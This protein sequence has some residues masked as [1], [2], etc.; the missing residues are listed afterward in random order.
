MMVTMYKN[1]DDGGNFLK[2]AG[3]TVVVETGGGSGGSGR[4][5]TT[6]TERSLFNRA[7]TVP[8]WSR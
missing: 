4:E 2:V 1:I 5:R 6:K 8:W 3:F 7:S